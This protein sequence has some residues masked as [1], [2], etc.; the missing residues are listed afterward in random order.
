MPETTP[1]PARTARR[2][3]YAVAV[4][5]VSWYAMMA[6]HELGHVLAGLA[7][8]GG[9]ERV[10]LPLLGFSRTDL[11]PNPHPLPVAWAGPITGVL[12]P[13]GL[14]LLAW[15]MFRRR[16][17]IAEQTLRFFAGFCLIANGA[18]LGLGWLDRI[19]DAG[20]LLRHGSPTWHLI[21][22]GL[23]CAAL[24]LALWHGIHTPAGRKQNH[25]DTP[26]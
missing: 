10:V 24:G 2:V 13:L 22:F 3:A 15:A 12:V 21:A 7:T 20:D 26:H 14:W 8:G 19:G 18:Y 16:C 4:L 17:R 11:A 6:V 5:V 1:R 9:V 23:V 25:T